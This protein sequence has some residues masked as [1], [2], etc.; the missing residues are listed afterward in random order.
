MDYPCSSVR[1]RLLLVST[2][3]AATLGTAPPAL[4]DTFAKQDLTIAGA[5][6]TPLAATLYEPTSAPPA[7]RFPAIV[8]FHGLGGTRASMNVLAEGFF[9][10]QGYVVLTFDARGHGESGGLWGLDGPNENADA[11]AVYAFLAAR[12]EVGSGRIGALGVSLGGA[13]VWNSAVITPCRT[14]LA[15]ESSSEIIPCRLPSVISLIRFS[16]LSRRM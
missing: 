6:G 12:P 4:A 16:I 13:A 3:V 15:S 7:G 8:M 5:G 1:V 10:T 11:R 14:S 2:L 9:A